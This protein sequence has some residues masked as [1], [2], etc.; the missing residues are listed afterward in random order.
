M[1]EI[2]P[3]FNWR[4]KYSAEHDKLSPFYGRTYNELAY[5]TKIYNYFIHPQWDSI[6]SEDLYVK[7]IYADYFDDYAIIE[8]FGEWND[9]IENDIELLLR[10]LIYPLMSNDI[11]KFI[12]IG[13]NILNFHGEIDDHYI[14]WF[15]EVQENDGWIVGL[16]FREHVIDEMSAFNITNYIQMQQPFNNI[17]WRPYE[18]QQVYESVENLLDNWLKQGLKRLS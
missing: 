13:E 16:N 11:F 15:E 8:L 2:E 18:P 10:N 1:H 7:I 17:K 9:A 6:G 4:D 3:H 12:L 5:E 14:E